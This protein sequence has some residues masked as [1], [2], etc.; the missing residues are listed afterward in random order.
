MKLA[1]F[2]AVICFATLAVLIFSA[3]QAPSM[4]QR[5]PAVPTPS[6]MVIPQEQTGAGPNIRGQVVWGMQPVPGA[7]VELRDG[8]WATESAAVL[9]QTTADA[10]GLFTITAA[11]VGEYG[12]VALW[13]DGGANKAAVTPVQIVAGVD[14]TDAIVRLAKEIPP[15]EPAS[16]AVV[17]SAPV[18]RWQPLAGALVYRVMVIDAGTTE[19]LVDE[20]IDGTVFA[21]TAALT[22]GHTYQWLA[23]GL[24]EAGVLLGEGD[25]TFTVGP[26]GE[27]ATAGSPQI[28][29]NTANVASGF[30]TETI[31]AVPAGDNVPPWEVLPSYSRITLHGY[32]IDSHLMKPQ[33]FIYPVGDLEQ[34]NEGT[35][36][37]V[38]SLR[39]LLRS[40]QEMANMPFLPLYNATQ[41]LHVHLQHLDFGNG[42]G[43]R[44][45]TQLSQGIVPVNN[46]EL[47]YTYQ[48]LTADG[49]YYV[50]AV[51][52][53]N[54][55]SLPPDGEVTG[56]EMPE[57]AGDFSAYLATVVATL[58]P[59]AANSF[60]PDLTQLDAMMSSLEITE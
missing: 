20:Q 59:Q 9:R 42:Q 2:S 45:L 51:L 44:Y 43:L 26:I 56:S 15:L 3:C 28:S 52:P 46:F 29:L 35:G 41:M 58:N 54:H 17:E 32:P 33:I 31:A 4:D 21:V 37:I 11:P 24:G 30:E 14:L 48:G 47:I 53:I 23:Q 1:R 25:S 50:A 27:T 39:A 34:V 57:F 55:P 5:L 16:G 49:K 19:L 8:A 13:P 7:T 22:P 18:L 38:A 40:P 10:G 6:A 60:T 12:L 36:P